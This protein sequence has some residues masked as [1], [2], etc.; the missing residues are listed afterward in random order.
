[1]DRDATE[2]SEQ[3]KLESEKAAKK[4]VKKKNDKKKGEGEHAHAVAE[5]LTI[6]HITH[7]SAAK[8]LK[9]NREEAMLAAGAEL[10]M[11]AQS[12]LKVRNF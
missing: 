5:K 7:K 8:K 2:K 6:E 3:Q 10:G 1:M 9:N 4:S 11:A 12:K